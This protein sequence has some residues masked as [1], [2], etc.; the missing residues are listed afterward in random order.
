MMIDDRRL[1][2]NLDDKLLFQSIRWQIVLIQQKK[3]PTDVRNKIQW[4]WVMNEP[5]KISDDVPD[6]RQQEI[7]LEGYFVRTSLF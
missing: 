5:V 4:S 1:I 7:L 6:S 3:K 2:I